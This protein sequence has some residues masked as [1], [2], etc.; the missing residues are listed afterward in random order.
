[1]KI[2]ITKRYGKYSGYPFYKY[3]I[4]NRFFTSSACDDLAVLEFMIERYD[5]LIIEENNENKNYK[6]IQSSRRA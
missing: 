5:E 2:I 6:D 1:M 4:P 3:C